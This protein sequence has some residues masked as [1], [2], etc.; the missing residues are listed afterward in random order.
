MEHKW[1]YNHRINRVGNYL[2]FDG[3]NGYVMHSSATGLGKDSSFAKTY[4]TYLESPDL[5]FQEI[6]LEIPVEGKEGA[7]LNVLKEYQ[8]KLEDWM[9]GKDE[10]HAL[11]NGFE[12]TSLQKADQLQL[13]KVNVEKPTRSADGDH[14]IINTHVNLVTNCRSLECQ[15]LNK[16]TAYFIK[17]PV[18]IVGFN[19]NMA[20]VTDKYNTISY[21]WNRSEAADDY[22]KS[23]TISGR[24]ID[25]PISCL[26]I[27]GIGIVLN[28]QHWLLEHKSFIVPVNYDPVKGEMESSINMTFL[29]WK[30]E[31][32]KSRVAPIKAK[33]AKK[34][35]G[36][37]ILDMNVSMIQMKR[38]QI[39]HDEFHSS[40]YWQGR[41]K[42]SN[43]EFAERIID[44]S[45][46][47]I[48]H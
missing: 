18:L 34:K 9:K 22:Q 17:V 42:D 14:L 25:F 40:Q 30:K 47:L 24:S 28:E 23:V 13:F 21:D 11:I 29:P 6:L 44:I 45:D 41:N 20:Y 7:L 35:K 4:Y 36:Y 15:V 1:T 37:A 16:K 2:Y 3:D 38:G 46:L 31:M 12:I 19:S 32:K 5:T 48:F 33:L 26:G 43:N 8:L 39:M 10:Y 27:K